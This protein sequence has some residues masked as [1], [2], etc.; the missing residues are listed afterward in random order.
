MQE[1]NLLRLMVTYRQN[2]YRNSASI[3]WSE[4]RMVLKHII[5]NFKMGMK[6]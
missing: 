5:D 3:T 2:H 1:L 6:Y 4:S